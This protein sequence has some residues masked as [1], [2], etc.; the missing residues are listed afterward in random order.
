MRGTHENLL[1]SHL[2]EFW[3]KGIHEDTP[4]YDIIIQIRHQFPLD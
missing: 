4:F 2:A 1:P 3:W